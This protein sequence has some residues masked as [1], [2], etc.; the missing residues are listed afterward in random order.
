MQAAKVLFDLS[1]AVSQS[2]HCVTNTLKILEHHGDVNGFHF[3]SQLDAGNAHQDIED[4]RQ[5][6]QA[7]L[8]I[9]I[10]STLHYLDNLVLLDEIHRLLL[11]NIA[12]VE[13]SHNSD[14]VNGLTQVSAHACV[15]LTADA[16]A[17]VFSLHC[18]LGILAENVEVGK[19]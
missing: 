10:S 14:S 2:V 15:R 7:L 9:F 16:I 17:L 6:A 5:H 3:A 13:G 8:E 12:L 19:D 18:V 11:A 4:F 1:I